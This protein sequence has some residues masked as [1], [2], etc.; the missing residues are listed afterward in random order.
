MVRRRAGEISPER[1]GA[2]RP[3]D[4][5][6]TS[7]HDTAY[8]ISD[9]PQPLWSGSATS[10]GRFNFSGS[11]S[12][13]Y[14]CLHPLGPYA[15]IIRSLERMRMHPLS[16][17]DPDWAFV[18]QVWAFVLDV[19][20]V[21]ELTAESAGLVGLPADALLSDEFELCQR[22]A[23]QF[24]RQDPQFPSVWRYPSAALPG[25]ENVVIF[26][27]RSM[28]SYGLKPVSP[29]QLPGCLVASAGRAP[30]ELLRVMRHVGDPGGITPMVQPLSFAVP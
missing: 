16:Q 18:H 29:I 11:T 20:D 23:E 12:T 19:T 14:F 5:F 7:L 21:F 25:T 13:Q 17:G 22:A 24:G 15:E 4:K 3:P 2:L 9:F 1:E 26:G 6:L 10:A 27:R 28:S 8:R 30:E